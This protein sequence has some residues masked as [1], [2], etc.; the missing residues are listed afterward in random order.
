V[1]RLKSVS[2]ID[3]SDFPPAFLVVAAISGV[4]ALLFR[5]LPPDAGAE[6]AG[7][8]SLPATRGDQ[9]PR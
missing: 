1:L 8:A 2:T 4:S 6:L 5:Q 9:P 7:G 3:A